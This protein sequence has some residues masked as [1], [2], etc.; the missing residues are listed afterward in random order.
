MF[1]RPINVQSSVIGMCRFVALFGCG[2][3]FAL[4]GGPV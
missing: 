4:I 1:E 2:F 3:S